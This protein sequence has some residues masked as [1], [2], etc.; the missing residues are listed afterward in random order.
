MK[1]RHLALALASLT[2]LAPMAHAEALR[3]EIPQTPFWQDADYARNF[4]DT[5]IPLT[6]A[7]PKINED[8]VELFQDLLE[9]IKVQPAAAAAR[10]KQEIDSN[11]SAAMVFVLG[12]L[13]LQSGDMALAQQY[14][15]QAI[16]KFENYRR[17]HK[18][19]GLVYFQQQQWDLALKH[20]TKAVEL[21]DREGAN[22]GRIGYCF[23]QQENYIAAENAYRDAIVQDSGKKD[24]K[25]GLAQ[26]L[27]AQNK[28]E[29]VLAMMHALLQEEP[30]NP[31]YWL[32]QVNAYLAADRLEEAAINLEILK[33]MGVASRQNLELLGNIYL[34]S[35]MPDQALG[36]F[37]EVIRIDNGTANKNIA[38][39]SAGL[40][41][42]LQSFDNAAAMVTAI[43]QHYQSSL[44][45]EEELEILNMEAKIARANG[46][47]ERAAEI[48]NTIVER[49]PTNGAA[50]LELASY[51]AEQGD[52]ARAE[53]KLEAAEKLEAYRFKAL[54]QRAQMYAAERRFRDAIPLL[55]EAL[56]IK[57][58]T[59]VENYLSRV[60]RA[61]RAM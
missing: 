25:L 6:D 41:L 27:L 48:L 11:S 14:Y 2:A 44:S 5:Y 40:F 42:Q 7:E 51:Y 3:A 24:W 60:E 18:N 57:D 54:V 12:N 53:F 29:E 46:E 19:L 33:A 4:L 50:L 32:F 39:K 9:L 10:L 17:A 49:D 47:A 26:A 21:G 34:R 28:T 31:Q 43:R 8:E 59:R 45:N 55:R 61:A 15:Q 1:I 23:L 36:A 52:I 30:G 58:D 38:M 35:N 13:Y 16:D 22:Y 20:M 37:Q 56:R